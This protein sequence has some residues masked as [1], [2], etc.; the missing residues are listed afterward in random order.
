MKKYCLAALS[1]FV[2]FV[3]CGVQEQEITVPGSV[4]TVRSMPRRPTPAPLRRS[5]E[6]RVRDSLDRK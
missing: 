4:K 1:A 3:G 5:R 2:V 6:R